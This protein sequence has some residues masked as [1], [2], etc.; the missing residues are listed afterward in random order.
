MWRRQAVRHGALTSVYAGSTP[1]A[2]AEEVNMQLDPGLLYEYLDNDFDLNIF[3]NRKEADAFLTA[4][5]AA[6]GLII[7]NGGQKV[8]VASSPFPRS[9]AAVYVHLV[10]TDRD[11]PQVEYWRHRLPLGTGRKFFRMFYGTLRSCEEG[12]SMQRR[13]PAD[14]AGRWFFLDE[15]TAQDT[16]GMLCE[17]E[18]DGIL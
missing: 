4:A 9:A 14:R 6:G 16:N 18:L 13:S 17:A 10:P 15:I 12:R 3:L 1:V 5:G 7:W 8:S 11:D 2:T